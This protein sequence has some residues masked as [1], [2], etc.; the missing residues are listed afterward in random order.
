M[1]GKKLSGL[2]GGLLLK[3]SGRI[4]AKLAIKVP[5]EIKPGDYPAGVIQMCQGKALGGVRV[6]ARVRG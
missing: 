4:Q 1:V 5:A 3:P 2:G 6:V